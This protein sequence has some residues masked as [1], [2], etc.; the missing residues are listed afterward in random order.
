MTSSR[1]LLAS[2]GLVL[3]A[4][5]MPSAA[6]AQTA[7]PSA[8]ELETARTLYKEGKELRAAGNLKGALEKLQAAHALGHT[9]VTGI[10]LAKTYVLVGKLVEARE[11][12]LQVARLGVASDETE[13][14]ADARAESAKLAESL[15]PRI[16]TLVVRIRG[17]AQGEVP[18][19]VLDGAMVPD[20]AI[21]EPQ[22]VDPGQHDVVV[23]VGDGASAREAHASAD[24]P[25]GQAV[26]IA[27]DVPAA[28]AGA[29]PPAATPEASPESSH[30]T[31]LLAK[32]AF[33]A[34]IGGTVVGVYGGISALSFESSVDSECPGTHKCVAGSAGAR[35]LGSAHTWADV[36]TVSFIIAGAGL[37]TGVVDMLVEPRHHEPATGSLRVTPWVSAGM[38]GVNGHF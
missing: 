9:P 5:I 6:L 37:V 25:E 1:R 34:A 36:S 4:M 20:V 35:D 29:E 8:A 22:S 12:A 26:L 19:L 7:P 21:A 15:R 30:G 2:A 28:P 33:G 31:P 27:V 3:A 23:R 24:T 16:P 18:H 14:S 38:A 32:L 17:L 10:E 13:K 11:V